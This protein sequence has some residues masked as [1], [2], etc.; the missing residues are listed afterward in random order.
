M[1]LKKSHKKDWHA[2]SRQILEG[3]YISRDNALSILESSNDDILSLLDATFILR[4]HYFGREIR[5]HVIQN[6]RRG[7]CSEDCS[8]CGQSRTASNTAKNHSLLSVNAILKGARAAY[9][10]K[11]VRNCIVTSGRQASARDIETI[12]EA[13]RKIKAELPIALCV[14]LGFLTPEHAARLKEAGIDRYNH[15][16]ETSE[17]YFPNVCTTHT[18]ADRI[19][20]AQTAKKAGLELCSGGLIGLGE[21]LADRVDLAFA[22]RDLKPD[23]IPVNFFDPR[24]GTKMEHDARPT[25][26]DCLKTLA[27]LRFV[28]PSTEIRAAGGRE[29]CLGNLQ[30][31]SL[32]AANSIF[33][34][35]YLTTSGQGY[36]A[37]IAMIKSAGFHVA[38]IDYS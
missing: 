9:R 11:A 16:L 31:F 8:F 22:L 23:S 17:N 37:D 1:T 35:G 33:T 10:M 29:A 38:E 20:T 4:R 32:F 21:T 3:K 19:A 34:N 27:M 26:L 28:N 24:P 13:A 7:G 2:L 36:D 5:L 14:S 6:A 18:Y 15:N 25:A 30:V 12:C